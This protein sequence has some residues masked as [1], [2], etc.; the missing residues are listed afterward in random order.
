MYLA[1]PLPL[2]IE[3]ANTIAVHTSAHHNINIPATATTSNAT[4]LLPAYPVC[5]V[6]V[7]YG[8]GLAVGLD[9]PDGL[10]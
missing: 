1:L 7:L 8:E 3:I 5:A 6:D 9:G 2:S 4:M 10:D